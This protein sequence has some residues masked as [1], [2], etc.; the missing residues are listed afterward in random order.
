MDKEINY[1]KLAREINQLTLL[2]QIIHSTKAIKKIR[3][4]LTQ[5]QILFLRFVK[6]FKSPTISDLSKAIKSTPSFVSRLTTQLEDGNFVKRIHKP[7]FRKEVF[8]ELTAK[9]NKVVE[10]IE[11]FDANRR[12]GVLKQIS[13]DL[14]IDKVKVIEDVVYHLS[15]KIKDDI[16]FL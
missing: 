16:K 8:V 15:G 9:G 6:I 11:D 12:I 10:Q 14:G 2:T 13:E 1:P 5:S 3:Y 7:K 4:D